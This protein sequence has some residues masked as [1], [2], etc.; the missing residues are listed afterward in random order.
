MWN[1][2]CECV[3]ARV[4]HSRY[5]SAD[6]EVKSLPNFN[7][8]TIKKWFLKQFFHDL[9]PNFENWLQSK[10]DAPINWIKWKIWHQKSD[11]ESKWNKIFIKKKFGCLK[12]RARGKN[13]SS[14]LF[15]LF[16]RKS[17]WRLFVNHKNQFRFQSPFECVRIVHAL[18]NAVSFIRSSIH[19]G[20]SSDKKIVQ[21]PYPTSPNS[22]VCW[23]RTHTHTHIDTLQS[24]TF[25]VSTYWQFFVTL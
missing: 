14:T 17:E 8:E 7:A 23:M 15:L 18:S 25:H 20:C 12:K 2:A 6:D 24:F 13:V 21:S 1:F 4:S 16:S 3:V 5:K 19:F 9:H 10:V 22:R 11:A